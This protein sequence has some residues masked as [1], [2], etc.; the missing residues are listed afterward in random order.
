MVDVVCIWF[1]CLVVVYAGV[2]LCL[3]FGFVVLVVCLFL[4]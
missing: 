3:G 1:L 4:G 2:V